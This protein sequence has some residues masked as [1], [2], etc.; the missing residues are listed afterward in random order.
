MAVSRN[1]E[2]Q[3]WQA[4][5]LKEFPEIKGKLLNHKTEFTLGTDLVQPAHYGG[6]K[7]VFGP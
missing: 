2:G 3:P 4:G 6:D 7:R 1:E 5:L